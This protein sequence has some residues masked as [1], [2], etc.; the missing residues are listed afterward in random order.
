MGT[1]VGMRAYSKANV[2]KGTDE[3]QYKVDLFNRVK[4]SYK[5]ILDNLDI[6]YSEE[7]AWKLFLELYDKRDCVKNYVS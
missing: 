7:A 3:E 5:A 4:E 2:P 6:Q 1:K